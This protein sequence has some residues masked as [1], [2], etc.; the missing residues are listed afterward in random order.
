[1][2]N[3]TSTF[4]GDL[5]RH[6]SE[7]LLK[8]TSGTIRFD[9]AHDHEIDY[10]LVTISKGD[11]Q[12][13]RQKRDADTVIHAETAFFDRMVS[14]QAQPVTAWLRNDI[15]AEGEFRLVILLE[16]LLPPPS[17]GHHPRAA[18]EHGRQR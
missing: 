8:K 14:G 1:M 2:S 16:R 9:L 11:V 12:V 17:G 15:T 4:F 10:W 3:A 6:G 13:S 7:R 5:S 18:R